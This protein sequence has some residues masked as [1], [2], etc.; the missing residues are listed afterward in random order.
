[1]KIVEY[2]EKYIEQVKD[3]LIELQE[4]IS[5]LDKEKYNILTPKFRNKYFLHLMEEVKENNGIIY[6]VVEEER[7]V[8][9]VAG[10]ILKEENTY[11]FK[12]PKRGFVKDLIITKDKRSLGYGKLLLQKIENYFKEV[13]CSAVRLD[14]FGYNENALNFYYKENYFKRVVEMQKNI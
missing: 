6:I 11:D 13:G 4:Y 1:M 7:V 3:L 14:V 9:L 8:G 10:Y 2:E 12:S 5:K